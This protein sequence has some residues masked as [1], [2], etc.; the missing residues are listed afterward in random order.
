M[1]VVRGCVGVYMYDVH[2]VLCVFSVNVD[3]GKEMNGMKVR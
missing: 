3:Y 1:W 2:V